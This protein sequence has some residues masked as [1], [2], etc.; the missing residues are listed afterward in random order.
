M[1]GPA[2]RVSDV[3]AGL[4]WDLKMCISNK[5]PG[6]AEAAGEAPL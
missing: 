4:G 2:P 3:A 6:D 1:L 5:F